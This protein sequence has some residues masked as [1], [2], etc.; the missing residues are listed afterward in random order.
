MKRLI[1]A[2][3]AAIALAAI[4]LNA[5]TEAAADLGR[6]DFAEFISAS[7][8]D[9]KVE[10]NIS[11]PLLR[12]AT[13]LVKEESPEVAALIHGLESI[14]VRV[15]EIT[16]DNRSEFEQ[17]VQDISS[18]LSDEKWEKLARVRDGNANVGIFAR[19]LD[20]DSISGIVVSVAEKKEAVFVNI[21]GDVALDAI[22]DL[23][24]QLNLPALDILKEIER[25]EK[26]EA[27]AG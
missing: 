16:D 26:G 6:I 13:S 8:N 25:T 2:F 11:K 27:H 20:D 12:L 14:R 18:K 19:I 9:A 5:Q 4:N 22:A 24:K 23:G 1:T 17:S 21:V 3:S 10:V 15:Y 7:P